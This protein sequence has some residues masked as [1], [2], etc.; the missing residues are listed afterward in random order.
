MTKVGPQPGGDQGGPQPGRDRDSAQPEHEWG[1]PQSGHGRGGP[2]RRLYLM[3]PRWFSTKE[4]TEMVNNVVYSI[5]NCKKL[6][7]F[8]DNINQ[9]WNK[10]KSH[11][12]RPDVLTLDAAPFKSCW[13]V[14]HLLQHLLLCFTRCSLSI[15]IKNVSSF[16][17]DYANWLYTCMSYVVIGNE[18]GCVCACACLLVCVC[19]CVCSYARACT[20]VIYIH[21]FAT[22]IQSIQIL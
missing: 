20:S 18:R 21:D 19:V 11:I 6:S 22:I 5:W 8:K 17:L 3:R 15:L 14:G 16:N 13:C 7:S 9:C 10:N 12:W 1:E 2:P 4:M